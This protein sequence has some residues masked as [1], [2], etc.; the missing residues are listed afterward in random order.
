EFCWRNHDLLW[1]VPG[2][3]GH[4]TLSHF[5]GRDCACALGR[6]DLDGLHAA[7]LSPRVHGRNKRTVE[8]TSGSSTSVACAGD[9][10]GSSAPLLR[11]FPAILCANGGAH[12]SHLS[13]RE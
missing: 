12:V 6:G 3:L 7:R 8:I 1:R 11:V 5:P 13:V 2:R 10:A 9:I 4:R